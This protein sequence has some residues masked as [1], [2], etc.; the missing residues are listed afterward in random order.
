MHRVKT[1]V[2][3]SDDETQTDLQ[4]TIIALKSQVNKL[5]HLWKLQRTQNQ[6]L[7]KELSKQ[8]SVIKGLIQG[9]SAGDVDSNLVLGL[10][11]EL[12]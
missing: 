10:K 9:A 12:D 8:D 5:S 1:L 6:V 7:N 2:R 3:K 4:A 11:R